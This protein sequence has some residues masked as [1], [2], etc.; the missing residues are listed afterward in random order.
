MQE[1]KP[2]Q[3]TQEIS[4]FSWIASL[5]L[6]IATF[7]AIIWLKTYTYFQENNIIALNADIAQIETD[8]QSAST[9]KDIIVANILK[10]STIRPSLDLKAFVSA[11]RRAAALAGV[12]LQWFSISNDTVSTGLIATR[13]S[14]NADPVKTIIAMMRNDHLGIKLSTIY[15]VGGTNSERTT[16]VTFQILPT[17]SSNNVSK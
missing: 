11:F 3:I 13:D 12:R 2:N 5:A 16:G 15:G 6:L 1:H 17:N 8:I 9:D 4:Q 7:I 14:D 10:S